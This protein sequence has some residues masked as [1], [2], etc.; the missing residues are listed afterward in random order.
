MRKLFALILAV[1]MCLSLAACGASDSADTPQTDGGFEKQS[2][3]ISYST[4]DQG[5]D[6][7]AANRLKELVA[8]KTDGAVT[9]ECYGNAQLAGGDMDRMLELLIQ[10]GGYDLCI[11]SE[12][13]ME[14]VN[15][16]FYILESPFVFSSYEDAYNLLDSDAGHEWITNEFAAE[17]LTYLG[18]LGNGILQ[19]TNSKHEIRTPSDLADIRF[20]V[21]GDND[22]RLIKALGGD[23][24]VMSFSELYSA[25]Q[26]GTVDGQINGLQ[27]MASAN[28]QE[29]QKY[30]TML[31]MSLSSSH[32]V[33][34]SAAF[35]KY[36]PELQEVLKECAVEAAQYARDYLSN[37]EAELR[38]KFEESGMVFYDPTEEELAQFKELAMPV[39]KDNL[40]NVSQETIEIFGLN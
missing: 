24:F 39:L 12:A 33:A 23:A 4:G 28:L 3:K 10:G 30:C 35:E 15:P 6:G 40:S 20:R 32:I 25:L 26:Q 27:T 7:I 19:M 16:N 38:T 18:S 13:V 9:I 36:S 1:A 34:N 8:E 14:S 37:Q 2:I 22:M 31:N 11:L 29:V 17:G 21:Y 5:M